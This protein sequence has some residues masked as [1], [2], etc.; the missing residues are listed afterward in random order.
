MQTITQHF[1]QIQRNTKKLP[2]RELGWVTGIRTWAN[3]WKA[4]SP[5]TTCQYHWHK[6]FLCLSPLAIISI[7]W[8]I[9]AIRLAFQ[10]LG[11]AKM[12][13]I[14]ISIPHLYVFDI[15]AHLDS[16]SN[17]HKRCWCWCPPNIADITYHTMPLHSVSR[18]VDS[19]I[20]HILFALAVK[21]RLNWLSDPS[22]HS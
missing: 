6:R 3:Y 14:K 12:V 2:G 20:E 21:S 5:P 9:V 18:K 11:W 17:T 1:Y 13:Q 8:C 19:V 22:T 15:Y 4:E 10:G 16:L 7:S